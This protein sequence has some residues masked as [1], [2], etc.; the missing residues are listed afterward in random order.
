MD[1]KKLELNEQEQAEN[2]NLPVPTKKSKDEVIQQYLK[3]LKQQSETIKQQKSQLD[4]Y[5]KKVEAYEKAQSGIEIVISQEET[6][7]EDIGGLDSVISEI[8]HFDYAMQYPQMYAAYGIEPPKGL[9]MHGPPGC[10]KTMIAKAMSNEL[11]CWF[12]EL[13]LTQ[14]ISKY[15]GEAE[16]NL[17]HMLAFAKQQ[18]VET[19]KPVMIFVDEAEQMFRERGTYMSHGVLDRCVNVWLRT[20]DG[21]GSNEGLI[22]VAA[23]N[24]LEF[25]DDAVLRAGRFDYVLEIPQPDLKGVEEIFIKQMKMKEKKAEREIYKVENVSHLAQQMYDKGMCGADIAEVLKRSSMQRIRYFIENDK[26][27]SDIVRDEVFIY[28]ADLKKVVDAYDRSEKEDAWEK[29]VVGF[30]AGVI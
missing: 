11:D 18:Y 5:Q 15:V 19:D 22:F 20:M 2:E 13:P 8:R 30:T 23:T 9:L 17:E 3:V 1:G 27:E 4:F 7:F 16:Q 26:P 24:Y 25:I 29:R 12:M 28:D 14:I 6:G 21:M 10:G